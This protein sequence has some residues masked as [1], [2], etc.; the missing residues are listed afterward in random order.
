VKFA[1]ASIAYDRI[2]YVLGIELHVLLVVARQVHEVNFKLQP[3]FLK[4][5]SATS[6]CVIFMQHDVKL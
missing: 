4:F 3:G 1:L 5:D 6:D 2:G